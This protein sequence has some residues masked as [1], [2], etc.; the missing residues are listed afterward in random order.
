MKSL[1]YS[2]LFLAPAAL[3]QGGPPA[4]FKPWDL[5]LYGVQM[6][7]G[8]LAQD[9]SL[10]DS[11]LGMDLGYSTRLGP[12]WIVGSTV[13]LNRRYTDF[14]RDALFEGQLP[15]WEHRDRIG[16]GFNGIYLMDK[17]W[18]F[19]LAPRFQW[20]AAKDA[21]L[22]DGFSWGVLGGAMYSMSPDLQL[23]FGLSYLNDVKETKSFPIVLVKWQITERLKLDNPFEP[24]FAGRAGLEL[25]Y[26]WNPHFE[27]G[28]G[29]AYRSDRFALEGGAAELEEP[30]AFGR[31]SYFPN[32]DWYLSGIIGYRTEGEL[33][34]EPDGAANRKQDVDGR[35]GFAVSFNWSF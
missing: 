27:L 10:G 7:D 14:S 16:L 34:W 12:Q 18:Q 17:Q 8:D 21:S 30:V 20:S 23:G 11:A 28:V 1:W 6:A 35:L 22:S 29:G 32:E 15:S 13:S 33:N 5:T 31:L 25:S 4:N 24:G 2:L 3:A 19:I 26:R 9:G